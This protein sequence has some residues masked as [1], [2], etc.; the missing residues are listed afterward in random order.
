MDKHV[1]YSN[2]LLGNFI[3]LRNVLVSYFK[4][5]KAESSPETYINIFQTTWRHVY[6][7]ILKFKM[8]K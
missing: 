5:I 7:T 6:E 2:V 8:T 4:N 1:A 3:R